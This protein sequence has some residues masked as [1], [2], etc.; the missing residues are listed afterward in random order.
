MNIFIE[1]NQISE[2][3]DLLL[4]LPMFRDLNNKEE[5][6]QLFIKVLNDLYLV[7]PE[8]VLN[9]LQNK[10]SKKFL[11]LYFMQMGIDEVIIKTIPD[12]FKIKLIYILYQLFE[13]RGT[14]QVYKYFAEILED[15]TGQMNFY[16]VNIE[17]SE[18]FVVEKNKVPSITKIEYLDS[19][20][21]NNTT[22]SYLYEEDGYFNR[23][24]FFKPSVSISFDYARMKK[25]ITIRL[26]IKAWE[27][28]KFTLSPNDYEVSQGKI[29]EKVIYIEALSL[30]GKYEEDLSMY[31]SQTTG[32]KELK[33][34]L[35]PVYI[36]NEKNILTELDSDIRTHK[37]FMKL[38]QYIQ[39]NNVSVKRLAFPINTNVL[40]IQYSS[41]DDLFDTMTILP[42][43][44]RYYGMTSLQNESFFMNIG[45]FSGRIP[46]PDYMD[47]LTYIKLEEIK[48]S[49][50]GWDFNTEHSVFNAPTN[51]YVPVD[52]YFS[53]FIYPKE[54]LP[55]IEKLMIDYKDMTLDTKDVYELATLN[56]SQQKILKKISSYKQYHDFKLKFTKLMSSQENLQIETIFNSALFKEKLTGNLPETISKLI[57]DLVYFI[58]TSTIV[59]ELNIDKQV[60]IDELYFL[61]D[62]Y[63]FMETEVDNYIKVLT[64]Y[65]SANYEIFKRKITVKY[66]RLIQEIDL[67]RAKADLPEDTLYTALNNIDAV[68][69]GRKI[70]FN[71]FLALYKQLE[72]DIIKKDEYIKYFFKDTYMRLILGSTFK[73]EFF[74][75]L[76]NLFNNYFFNIDQSY[77]NS[78][79]SS[80]KIRNK[81]NYIPIDSESNFNIYGT[82]F[83]KQEYLNEVGSTC[84]SQE[85]NNIP[86]QYNINNTY[87]N[88]LKDSF[89]TDSDLINNLNKIEKEEFRINSTSNFENIK[90]IYEISGISNENINIEIFR[91]KID[92]LGIL[93]YSDKQIILL[94]DI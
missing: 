87:T 30:T 80:F 73:N 93:D 13:V 33:Y 63:E 18:N 66:P 12:E 24:P 61:R 77:F 39:R 89:K 21:P 90:Q 51:S 19:R 69:V 43:L 8:E 55:E 1:N 92:E 70:Y 37:Y 84:N 47:I 20:I 59:E 60:I 94:E 40:Y 67:L 29:D 5:L 68:P 2:F 28:L 38:D 91:Y 79:I 6:K 22:Y 82:T 53:N 50:P 78:D 46:L 64:D 52:T 86:T 36:M 17:Q 3:S 56:G 54:K 81:M 34:K 58:N 31:E 14:T 32:V 48:Y 15:I 25:I 42:D 27:K 4:S 16:T 71:T 83:S 62:E 75:P 10:P 65:S 35:K 57:E 76:V 85:K 44:V 41:G 88:K 49:N 11:T 26:N 72:P 45:N 7:I 74:D 9:F 23:Y